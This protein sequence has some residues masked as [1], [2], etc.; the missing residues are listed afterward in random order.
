MRA[1]LLLGKHGA[2]AAAGEHMSREEPREVQVHYWVVGPER[3]G[4]PI[5]SCGVI[6]CP[7]MLD[8]P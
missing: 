3:Y 2:H 5:C 6:G 4:A 1:G 8:Q 7:A